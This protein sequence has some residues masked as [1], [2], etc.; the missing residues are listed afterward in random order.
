MKLFK[1]FINTAIGQ[2]VW[3]LFVLLVVFSPPYSPEGVGYSGYDIA[4][5]LISSLLTF[6][7]VAYIEAL[8]TKNLSRWKTFAI[9]LPWPTYAYFLISRYLKIGTDIRRIKI[10]LLISS[11]LFF[12]ATFVIF[13]KVF[14]YIDLVNSNKQ[15]Y[16][17]FIQAQTGAN[18]ALEKLGNQPR[19][20]DYQELMQVLEK[21]QVAVQELLVSM[22]RIE[23]TT[24]SAVFPKIKDRIITFK[25][26]PNHTL[27]DIKAQLEWNREVIKDNP[28]T[29][30]IN[31]FLEKSSIEHKESDKATAE[32]EKLNNLPLTFLNVIASSLLSL[33]T[34]LF[35]GTL[36]L[37]LLIINFAVIVK[38]IQKRAILPIV[39][40][41]FLGIIN[42]ISSFLLTL[43]I[44]WF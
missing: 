12:I 28:D 37:V 20:S 22:D 26:Y 7:A 34:A 1:R 18:T 41:S 21:E 17:N 6:Y 2:F 10:F 24:L 43:S 3:F 32:E 25:S 14:T 33:S 23:N 19:K 4:K 35:L 42:S 39:G 5:M 16:D 29:N 9:L 13:Y 11:P 30:K 36:S 38:S 27:E 15:I 8:K 44:F 31:Q 40:W